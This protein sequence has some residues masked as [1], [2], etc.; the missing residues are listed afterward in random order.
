MVD[1]SD[2]PIR[3]QNIFDSS[4]PEEQK[5]LFQILQE[6]AETGSSETYENVWLSDYKEIPVD[7]RT[8]LCDDAYLGKATRNGEAIYPHWMGVMEEIFGA[9]NKYEEVVF[10]GATRIGKSSTAISCIAYMLYKLMC[11]RDPQS[12][13]GK[14]DISKFSIMF[15]NIT[16]DLARGVAFREF[17]DTLRT[18]PWFNSHGSW[19]KSE[20]NFYYIPEGGK[21]SVEYGS[22]GAHALGKQVFCLVGDTKM[23]TPHG[24]ITLAEA[25]NN[26]PEQVFS[27]ANGEAAPSSFDDVVLT[28]YTDTTIRVELDDGTIIEGTPDHLVQ[29]SDGTYKEL[30]H[31]TDEDDL[32]EAEIWKAVPR[33]EGIYEVSTFGNVRSLDRYAE[34][35]MPWGTQT[36][37]VNGHTLAV[38]NNEMLAVDLNKD[39]VTEH[40]FVAK[41]VLLAF[42]PDHRSS[43]DVFHFIDDDP[44]NCKLSNLR[45]GRKDLGPD[46]K[47]VPNTYGLLWASTR[48][49]LYIRGYYYRCK[50]A[51]HFHPAHFISPSLDRNGYLYANISVL[52]FIHFVHQA[53]ASA[54]IPN[55][56]NKPQVNHI[57][58]V[59]TNNSPSNLEWATAKENIDH[60]FTI[61]LRSFDAEVAK[62]KQMAED[63]CHPVTCVNT[64]ETFRSIKDAAAHIGMSTEGLRLAVINNRP[65][66]TGLVFRR[67]TNAS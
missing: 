18:S 38:Q 53:V 28:K 61:G 59:K 41:L 45:W 67:C 60:A 12:F 40:V 3:I 23:V 32:M 15:F 42:D 48:G 6:L 33:Y 35:N 24:V 47:A 14:K 30:Q 56:D 17:N 39:G 50:G 2:L 5:Y 21:I 55:P 27:F 11:L 19:S 8:F 64:G 62:C 7:I 29:L 26:P 65:T 43:N 16:K 9:G 57:D 51:V 52:P 49:S 46:W 25:A 1:Y 63:N 36:Y 22:M 66:K 44:T 4:T 20:E 54:F 10:T 37:R 31:L 34:R 13:Y 58:G